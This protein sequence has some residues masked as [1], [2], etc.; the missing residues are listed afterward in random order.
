MKLSKVITLA[1]LSAAFLATAAIA[2]SRLLTMSEIA[3]RLQAVGYS[4]IKEIEFEHGLYYAEVYS[5]DGCALK[6][7]IDPYTGEYQRPGVNKLEGLSLSDAL[8]KAAA[9]GYLQVNRAEVKGGIYEL[10]ALDAQGHKVKVLV[11]PATG[12]LSVK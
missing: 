11:D 8:K 1:T 12:N 7:K 6:L 5:K 2:D 10:R 4:N 9:A 3:K